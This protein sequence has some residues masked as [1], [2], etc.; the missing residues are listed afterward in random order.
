MPKH[1]FEGLSGLLGVSTQSAHV[2]VSA[3]TVAACALPRQGGSNAYSIE[4]FAFG[5]IA[6]F[7]LVFL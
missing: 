3:V 4:F 7:W 5:L 1:W 6:A 2:F